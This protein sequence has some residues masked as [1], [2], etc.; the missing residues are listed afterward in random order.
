MNTSLASYSVTPANMRAALVILITLITFGE[1]A[2]AQDYDV[3]T[4]LFER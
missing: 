3:V 2:V 4:L 1:S